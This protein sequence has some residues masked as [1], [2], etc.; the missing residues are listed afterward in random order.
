[1]FTG[2]IQSVGTIT[3]LQSE[4][5]AIKCMINPHL[6]RKWKKGESVS[7]NG[8]C[9]TVISASGHSFQVT[10]MPHTVNMTTTKQWKCGT[11]VNIEPSL[12]AGD[13]ISGHFVMGHID[14]IA[15]IVAVK[16]KT[17][18]TSFT[19]QVPRKLLRYSIPR[20]SVA[21]DGVSLTIAD[22]HKDIM[23]VAVTPFTLSHTTLSY[24][25]K[26]DLLNIEIDTLARYLLWKPTI[27]KRKKRA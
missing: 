20:G 18:Q 3:A 23:T 2:I 27:S 12:K 14:G 8:I 16:P 5:D 17:G 21:L 22:V 15:R 26:N 6:P 11:R 1:M 9:S 10:Y 24:V 25:C 7:V 19:I 13:E 4:G